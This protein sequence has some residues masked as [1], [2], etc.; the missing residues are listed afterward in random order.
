MNE[1]KVYSGPELNLLIDI[2]I[3]IEILNLFQK[4]YGGVCYIN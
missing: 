2:Q 1:V 4:I 3:S